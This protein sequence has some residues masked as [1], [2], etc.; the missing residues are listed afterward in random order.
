MS[1]SKRPLLP[2][3]PNQVQKLLPFD[4][5]RYCGR[6]IIVAQDRSRF[7]PAAEFLSDRHWFTVLCGDSNDLIR[8]LSRRMPDFIFVATDFHNALLMET[9]QWLPREANIKLVGF[10]EK[11][12]LESEK[13]L[14]ENPFVQYKMFK[15]AS[16]PTFSLKL[17]KILH[18]WYTNPS[19][20]KATLNFLESLARIQRKNG[21][22]SDAF[23]VQNRD[24]GARIVSRQTRVST[25]KTSALPPKFES[26]PLTETLGM[27]LNGLV[28]PE[29]SPNG[30]LKKVLS[31]EVSPVISQVTKGYLI[32]A[33]NY[34]NGINKSLFSNYKGL[35]MRQAAGTDAP[36]L[37]GPDFTIKSDEFDFLQWS[38]NRVPH[39]AHQVKDRSEVASGIVQ[40]DLS[41]L[42]KRPLPNADGK[43]ALDTNDFPTDQIL[44]FATYLYL[45]ENKRYI[46]Y[47]KTG[48]VLATSQKEKLIKS[49]QTLFIDSR[50]S[51]AFMNLYVQHQLQSHYLSPSK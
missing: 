51:E 6:V 11:L 17:R 44:H 13:E 32:F 38:Q 10:C 12:S 26:R 39:W 22:S 50:D 46:P 45:K 31:F 9:I 48:S 19:T 4:F 7:E 30:S 47:L 18:D 34:L 14:D 20:T 43:L 49:N 23:S 1:L 33:T 36:L 24:S 42:P 35:L 40:L 41:P 25:S 2:S 37:F 3:E 16:G 28:F 8:A 15:N 5:D 27:A 29:E 21:G